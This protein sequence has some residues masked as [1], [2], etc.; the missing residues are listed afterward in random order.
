MA[1]FSGLACGH[2]HF[3]AADTRNT[4][5]ASALRFSKLAA[6]V[7]GNWRRLTAAAASSH[8]R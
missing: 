8:G 2:G 3:E 6:L 4:S 7:I 1:L 5:F